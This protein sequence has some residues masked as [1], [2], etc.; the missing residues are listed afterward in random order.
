MNC[1]A[2]YG[3]IQQAPTSVPLLFQRR[4]LGGNTEHTLIKALIKRK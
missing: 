1:L 2:R 4:L 3:E